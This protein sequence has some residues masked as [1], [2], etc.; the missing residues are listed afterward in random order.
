M[1]PLLRLFLFLSYSGDIGYLSTLQPSFSH[2]SSSSFADL[3]FDLQFYVL[4]MSAAT[5]SDGFLDRA[6]ERGAD[7]E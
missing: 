7:E 6:D 1:R 2:F 3:P 5:S 4:T